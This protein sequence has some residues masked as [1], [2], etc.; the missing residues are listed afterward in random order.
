VRNRITTNFSL[1]FYTIIT[2]IK[3]FYY[4]FLTF[5]VNSLF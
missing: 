5:Q 1:V 4:N 3:K 2:W